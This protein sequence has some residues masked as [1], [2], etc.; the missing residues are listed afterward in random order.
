[1]RRA[2]ALLTLSVLLSPT[3]VFADDEKSAKEGFKQIHQGM[4]KVTKSVDKNAKKGFKR[5]HK[6]AKKDVKTVD[7]AAKKGWKDVGREIKK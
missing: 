1:M 3:P 4:K 7:K 5:V 6:Q 2:L